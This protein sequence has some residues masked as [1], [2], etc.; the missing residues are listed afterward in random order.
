MFWFF[1]FIM[2][3][4]A[5]AL[6]FR[7]SLLRKEPLIQSDLDE[8]SVVEVYRQRFEELERDLTNGTLSSDQVADSR[9]ELEHALLA[10]IESEQFVSEERK[11][12]S[13]WNLNMAVILLLPILAVSLYYKIGQP[14][15]ASKGTDVALSE[16]TDPG[17]ENIPS[18]EELVV[19]LE[20]KLEDNPDDEKGL[21]MLTRTYMALGRQEDALTAVTHL[22]SLASE[23]PAV[24]LL[25]ANVLILNNNNNFSGEPTRLIE[26]ALQL[27][28]QNITGLWLAGM[29]ARQSDDRETAIRYW[30]ELLPLLE[31]DA[32]AS[33][34]IQQLLQE[35]G[36]QPALDQDL[37]YPQSSVS[38]TLR[39]TL[40]E[41][42]RAQLDEGDTL[43][44]FA[45][46][47]DGMPMPVAVSRLAAT[48]IPVTVV[49][50]DEMA[51]IPSRR[52]SAFKQVS[53]A[54]RISKTGNAIAQSGDL[55]SDSQEIEV[56]KETEINLIINKTIP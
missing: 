11:N 30:Q 10:E 28:P 35:V 20:E 45:R 49:L 27:E 12:N 15:L 56:G 50:N 32:A 29:A 42:L 39:V 5:L 8:Q 4:V 13:D 6:V 3:L 47:D 14:D 53:V 9:L 51:M 21:W 38:L 52:L 40:A 41:E 2:I 54:A 23:E 26:Q 24:I 36:A 25:Y 48:E 22:H 1:A 37:P 17:T 19:G 46:A 44:V 34:Q 16:A 55:A 31:G 43:F 7:D 18:I 33:E